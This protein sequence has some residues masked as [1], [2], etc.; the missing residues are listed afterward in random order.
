MLSYQIDKGSAI[1]RF[2]K[3]KY[4]TMQNNRPITRFHGT[5]KYFVHKAFEINKARFVT[6]GLIRGW[7]FNPDVFTSLY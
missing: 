2:C 1:K 6:F 5:E 7:Y 3:N 4:K